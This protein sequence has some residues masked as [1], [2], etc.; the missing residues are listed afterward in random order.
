M[1]L[2]NLPPSEENIFLKTPSQ[3]VPVE[4]IAGTEMK[5]LIEDMRGTM[6]HWTGLGLAAVQVLKPIKLIVVLNNEGEIYS[7][8]NAKIIKVSQTKEKMLE[9]CMSLPGIE[10]EVERPVGITVEYVDECGHKQIKKVAGLEAKIIQHEVDHTE[11][12]L[13]TDRGAPYHRHNIG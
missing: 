13:I 2:L 10:V 4:A 9:G 1:A 3:E 12:I 5:Q 11:G 8:F 7:L 6:H